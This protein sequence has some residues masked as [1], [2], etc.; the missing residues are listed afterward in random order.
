MG[1]GF[2]ASEVIEALPTRQDK[3]A[4]DSRSDQIG[5]DHYARHTIQPWDALKQW[6]TGMGPF[7]AYMTGNAIKYLARWH[8]KNGA[9]DLRKAR[10]YIDALLAHMGES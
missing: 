4:P 9:E 6:L 8:L 7:E 3:G 10:H 5:G 1:A 2:V